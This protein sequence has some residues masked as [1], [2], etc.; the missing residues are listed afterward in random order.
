VL[1]IGP[2]IAAPKADITQ[3]RCGYLDNPTPANWWLTDRDG[4]WLGLATQKTCVSGLG[5]ALCQFVEQFQG[6]H[7]VLLG[8]MDPHQRDLRSAIGWLVL[9]NGLKIG[10]CMVVVMLGQRLLTARHSLLRAWRAA[11][12]K[13]SGKRCNQEGR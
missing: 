12:Q 6:G 7:R 9:Q 8:D 5:S 11:R 4:E 10:A 13:T 3:K 1:A 2:A